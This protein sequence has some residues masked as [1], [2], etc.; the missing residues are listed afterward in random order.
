MTEISDSVE[1]NQH[2][3]ARHDVTTRFPNR[4]GVIGTHAP[5]CYRSHP[6]CAYMLGREDER[7]DVVELIR[8]WEAHAETD[9]QMRAFHALAD[10][11]EQGWA[12]TTGERAS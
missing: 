11:I 12:F 8:E 10:G 7:A 6:S 5:E 4:I 9:E 3:P 2:D 1:S